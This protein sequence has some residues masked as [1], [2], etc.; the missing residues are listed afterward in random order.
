MSAVTRRFRQIVAN[1]RHEVGRRRKVSGIDPIADAIDYCAAE[2]LEAVKEAEH[3]EAPLTVAEYAALTGKTPATVR[4]WIRLGRL[5]AEKAP[6]GEYQIE[7]TA[8][9]A[10]S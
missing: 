1:W 2:L 5:R 7:R 4:K 9:A 3:E 8:L 10:A 6:D